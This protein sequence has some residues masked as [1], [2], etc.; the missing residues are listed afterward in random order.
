[1]YVTLWC[2]LPTYC[3]TQKAWKRCLPWAAGED[4]SGGPGSD[5]AQPCTCCHMGDLQSQRKKY[6][7]KKVPL[8]GD[9]AGNVEDG[10]K[11]WDCQAVVPACDLQPLVL[12]HL[13]LRFLL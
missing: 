11:I 13:C 4:G 9:P 7:Q 2:Y 10:Q 6:L 12:I 1:M 5:R 3:S 8:G